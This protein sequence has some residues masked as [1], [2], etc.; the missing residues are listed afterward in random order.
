MRNPD[1]E[2]VFRFKQ[3]DVNNRLSA[4]KVGTDGVLLGA[5]SS[6]PP[7]EKKPLP[8]T[9]CA[10]APVYPSILDVG[11]G[12]G[13]IALMLAQRCQQAHIYGIE[14]DNIAAD[15]AFENFAA[16]PWADRLSVIKGDFTT[17][18]EIVGDQK[19]DLIVS[20]PP[21]FTNGEKSPDQARMAA[22]HET[23]LPLS[24]LVETSCHLL[25]DNGHI[26]IVLPVD[27]EEELKYL[28]VVNH[29]CL[30]RLTRVST[31]TTK[32]PR[33]ILAELRRGSSMPTILAQL[34]IHGAD[35]GFSAEY[36]S[37][38]KDFYLNF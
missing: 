36:T 4:M 27:R 6:L 16:S 19:F 9:E 24:T 12:T 11:C 15:E 25:S 31:V 38:V 5:W 21:F 7:E 30:S 1:R 29:L 8:E 17:M 10:S 2:T 22:R 26:C 32:P 14:I 37:L 35:G 33:R 34:H 18:P 28:A 23:S 20:N 3:F 13:L